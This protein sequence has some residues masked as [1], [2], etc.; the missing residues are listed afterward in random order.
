MGA[1]A[2]LTAAAST[3]DINCVKKLIN[4]YEE[5]VVAG[6][7]D[8][9]LGQHIGSIIQ[10]LAEPNHI[11]DMLSSSNINE[12]FNLSEEIIK[13]ASLN[14]LSRDGSKLSDTK[15]KVESALNAFAQ[16]QGWG[17]LHVQSLT[18]AIVT[19]KDNF[20]TLLVPKDHYSRYPSDVYY[21]SQNVMLRSTLAAHLYNTVKVG[22]QSA[23]Y[24]CGDIYR[25]IEE[26]A[27]QSEVQHKLEFVRIF[28]IPPVETETEE[29]QAVGEAVVRALVGAEA[30][31]LRWEESDE[32]L[33]L[34]G[35]A[36]H[37]LQTLVGESIVELARGG[38]LSPEML[39]SLGFD[40]SKIG[41]VITF[42]LDHIA[43]VLNA[44]FDIRFLQA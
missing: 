15:G 11:G 19:T 12:F 21:C 18:S 27:W 1:G 6:T 43:M 28:D 14:H 32:A 2:S 35:D 3:F 13:R 8:V 7:T 38:R 39:L 37:D 24:A 23:F 41:Y 16:Q 34:V 5:K 42:D 22:G 33:H 36:Y 10:S 9:E 40:A 20:D 44:I 4:E 30:C 25:R 17:A 29:Y 26:D 31:K